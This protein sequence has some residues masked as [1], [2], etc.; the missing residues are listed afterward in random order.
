MPTIAPSAPYDPLTLAEREILF[1]EASYLNNQ[2]LAQ[3]EQACAYAFY[4]HDGQKRKTG[5][6][7]ITHPI[8]VTAE[9]AR[10]R[11]D[12]QALCAGLMHDVLEDTNITK[13][14]MSA[15]FGET[16]SEMVDGLSKLT[17]LEKDKTKDDKVKHQAESF[18]KL[19]LAMTKDIRVIV[20][21]L[22]DRLHNM[23]TLSAKSI[24]SRRRIATET[25]EIYAPIANRLGLN[26]VYRDLQDLSF[27][28][29][30][31]KRY[32]VLKRAMGA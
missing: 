25:L 32:L 27:Q 23:R 26:N 8:A 5:E 21:K 19:I 18:R 29:I 10:W 17:Q 11:M 7:Y 28:A 31:P 15:V 12:I 3:L 22:S 24:E 13:A 20:V 1:R 2:E 30:H 14:Q 16:I 6:P 9:L 4:A